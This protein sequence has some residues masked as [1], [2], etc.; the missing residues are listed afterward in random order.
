MKA[1]I[2][3][4]VG[5]PLRVDD[6]QAPH[7]AADEVL[8]RVAACGICGSDLHITEDPV[9]F[10]IGQGTVLGHEFAG[11]IISVG[12]DVS[13]LK[14]GDRVAVA[15]MWGCGRC[16]SCLRGEPAWCAQMRLIGGGYAELTAVAARQCRRLP[17]DLP[18]AEGALAEPTSVGL[19]AVNR[20][21]MKPGDKVLILGAGPIGLLVAFWA[22]RLGAGAIIVADLTNHQEE[23]AATVGATGFAISGPKLESQLKD[24]IGGKPD[25]VF[26][27]V[28]KKGLIDFACRLVRIH[29]TVVAVGLCVGG[30]DWDPFAAISKEI[31]VIFAVFFTMAEF[32]TAIDALGPG[33]F[34][35]QALITDRISFLQTPETFETLKRRTTQCKVLIDALAG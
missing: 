25:I 35:P 10:G 17:D 15:P 2:F 13:D 21:G 23:R 29:G 31:Q 18:T 6:V 26:E 30:D 16:E 24:M 1:A 7:P 34:R 19:H 32:A 33:R 14:P 5:R 3:D 8:L 12:S 27:C 28:G 22:R 11:E 4:G 9:T 20:S